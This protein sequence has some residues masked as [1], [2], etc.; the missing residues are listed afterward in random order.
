MW[1]VNN[2]TSS[3]IQISLEKVLQEEENKRRKK[4]LEYLPQQRRKLLT[5]VL[6]I[7]DLLSMKA[8]ETLKRI[9]A[10]LTEKWCQPYSWM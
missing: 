8:E 3:Y 5:F 1:V 10:G 9:M 4:Y 2:D 6:S 7:D